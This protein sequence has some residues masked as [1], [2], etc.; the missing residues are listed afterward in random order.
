[1]IGRRACAAHAL[2][3]VSRPSRAPS[4]AP[5]G[6]GAG[7]Q[8]GNLRPPA[9]P[10]SAG[11]HGNGCSRRWRGGVGGGARG[12]PP[13]HRGRGGGAGTRSPRA[14][15]PGDSVPGRLE[16]DRAAR[17]KGPAGRGHTLP[18]AKGPAGGWWFPPS[19]G[20]A[21]WPTAGEARAD[22][23]R[24]CGGTSGAP[25]HLRGAAACSPRCASRGFPPGSVSAPPRG[26]PPL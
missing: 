9:P 1:M 15:P 6:R 10:D 24:V 17:P 11:N 25:R 8:R 13:P 3:S 16:G 20:H 18:R 23:R 26:K 7:S 14:P 12:V 21:H 19:C 4:S 22:R 5:R 2:G